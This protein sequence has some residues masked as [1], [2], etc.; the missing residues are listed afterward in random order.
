MSA[1]SGIR[2]TRAGSTEIQTVGFQQ[3]LERVWSQAAMTAIL[4]E[5]AHELNQPLTAIT[6]HCDAALTNARSA[7]GANPDIIDDIEQAA[8]GA[9]NASQIVALLRRFMAKPDPP[10]TPV[11]LNRLVDVATQLAALESGAQNISIEAR[12]DPQL[13]ELILNG[14]Q[15]IQLIL[16]LLRHSIAACVRDDAMPCAITVSTQ[17]HERNV[18]IRIAGSGSCRVAEIGQFSLL[19]AI[20]PAAA[21][22]DAAICRVIV[23]AHNGRLWAEH[24]SGQQTDIVVSL[25][26]DSG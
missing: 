21:V 14:P 1:D 17:L 12:P 6:L 15:I 19:E 10:A 26:M 25:P 18:D 8:A 23:D 4:D 5:L 20:D 24:V 3:Q 11:Q 7:P 9:H 16:S 22:L 13:P 2:S